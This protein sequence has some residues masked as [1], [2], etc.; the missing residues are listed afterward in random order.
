MIYCN[1]IFNPKSILFL[2]KGT[3]KMNKIFSN[4]ISLFVVFDVYMLTCIKVLAQKAPL[5]I[6]SQLKQDRL[7][8]PE[9]SNFERERYISR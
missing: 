7:R 5:N 1:A 6:Y 8:I 3:P 2:S 9:K 4:L